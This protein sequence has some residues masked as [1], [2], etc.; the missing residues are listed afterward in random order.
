MH[1]WPPIGENIGRLRW[2]SDLTQ[3]ELADRAGVSVDLIRRLEQGNRN[4][5]RLSS[6][7]R[8]AAAL[9]VPLLALFG[10][11]TVLQPDDRHDGGSI[12]ALREVLT[13]ENGDRPEEAPSS[14]A[15]LEPLVADTW[16]N[17]RTGHFSRLAAMLPGLLASAEQAAREAVAQDRARTHLLLSDAYNVTS[18]VL[19]QLGYLDLAYIAAR[20]AVDAA[21]ETEDARAAAVA[22]NALIWILMRQGRFTTAEQTA[23]RTADTIE[24]R[25]GVTD[26]SH[27]AAWGSLLWSAAGSAV[28]NDRFEQADGLLREMRIIVD[29]VDQDSRDPRVVFG[30]SAVTMWATEIAVEREDYGEA[31]ALAEQVPPHGHVPLLTRTHHLLEVATA[32]AHT[33]PL[34]DALAT[35]L[36]VKKLAPEWMRYQLL[37]RETVR[38]L[39]SKRGASR[40]TDGLRELAIDLNVGV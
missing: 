17:Y 28:R 25:F 21:K 37:A 10:H 3:E 11:D 23:L 6:L 32:Q 26:P 5:A 40:R 8:I 7:Y 19:A 13:P 27:L 29:R 22:V 14:S 35:L 34:S 36:E 1:P 38:M 33:R 16:R 20:K 30:P 15:E 31:L 4:A 18:A 39:L 2:L 24:P 9:D 12:N